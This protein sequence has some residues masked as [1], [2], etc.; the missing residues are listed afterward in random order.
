M[1]RGNWKVTLVS[2]TANSGDRNNRTET[3]S[4]IETTLKENG[5]QPENFASTSVHGDLERHLPL[6]SPLVGW[7]KVLKAWDGYQKVECSWLP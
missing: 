2:T 4:A 7:E 6:K 1:M 5:F 3:I